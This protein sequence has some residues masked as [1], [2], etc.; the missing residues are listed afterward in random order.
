LPE[1]SAFDLDASTSGGNVSSELP[2]STT[3]KAIR[4]KLRGPVNGGGKSVILH[5]GGGSI[6]VKK[7]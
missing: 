6:Q 4:G 7:L 2:V 1:T 5:S 3:G